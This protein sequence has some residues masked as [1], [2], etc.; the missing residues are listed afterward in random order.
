[1][2]DKV[3]SRRLTFLDCVGAQKTVIKICEERIKGKKLTEKE[4]EDL[5]E[6]VA[7]ALL[8]QGQSRNISVAGMLEKEGIKRTIMIPFGSP[9]TVTYTL[10][11]NDK[12]DHL[13]VT[14]MGTDWNMPI[15]LLWK[16]L[17]N[18]IIELSHQAV[19]ESIHISREYPARDRQLAGKH[20]KVG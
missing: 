15:M 18:T 7:R 12:K 4:K 1:M 10:I 16:E 3:K 9:L 20:G 6:L 11:R 13:L 14:H 8:S 5:P 2:N 17:L 19:A